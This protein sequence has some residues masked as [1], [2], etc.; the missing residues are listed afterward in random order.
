[1]LGDA[2][3]LTFTYG[4]G[5]QWPGTFS[6]RRD[7]SQVQ[8]YEVYHPRAGETTTCCWEWLWTAL[9]YRKFL[10][11]GKNFDAPYKAERRSAGVSAAGPYRFGCGP[12]ALR[13]NSSFPFSGPAIH[14]TNQ[15]VKYHAGG[16]E[17][18]RPFD[19]HPQGPRPISVP[20]CTDG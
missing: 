20:K 19:S 9:P 12:V 16:A 17:V 5:V 3:P 1:M 6:S 7:R 15:I 2:V 10:F 13:R 18:K 14:L 4:A 11:F 8:D